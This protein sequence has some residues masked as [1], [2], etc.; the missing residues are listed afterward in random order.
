[1]LEVASELVGSDGWAFKQSRI[2]LRCFCIFTRSDLP[3]DVVE[4]FCEALV[5]RQHSIPWQGGRNLPLAQMCIDAIDAPIPLPLHPAAEVF[6][7]RCGYLPSVTT[8]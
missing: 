8:R 1:M 2:D 4:A 7:R 6:W 5:A 3:G